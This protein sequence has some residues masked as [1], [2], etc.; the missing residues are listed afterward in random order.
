MLSAI[1]VSFLPR[2]ATA[3]SCSGA[4][5][6]VGSSTSGDS[7][8]GIGIANGNYFVFITNMISGVSTVKYDLVST[9]STYQSPTKSQTFPNGGQGV[10]NIG[11]P[12]D[13]AWNGTRYVL[14]GSNDYFG[15][16]APGVSSIWATTN[17]TQSVNTSGTRNRIVYG[18][19]N[20]TGYFFTNNLTDNVNSTTKFSISTDG[21]TWSIGDSNSGQAEPIT[22]VAY[23][24]NVFTALF[25][26]GRTADS[27]MGVPM[28]YWGACLTN[29][30]TAN[31]STCGDWV[32]VEH[33]NVQNKFYAVS[34]LGCLTSG[35]YNNG[36]TSQCIT[37]GPV[38]QPFS[39]L[40]PSCITGGAVVNIERL[41]I[42]P[43]TGIFIAAWAS[44]S[45]PNTCR[46]A[47]ISKAN[48]GVNWDTVATNVRGATIYN[49]ILIGIG[50]VV[51]NDN[52]ISV[53]NVADC[54]KCPSGQC[55][56]TG[57]YLGSATV[58]SP[59]NAGYYTPDKDDT[60]YPCPTG[61]VNGAQGGTSQGS[62]MITC[63][64]GYHVATANAQCT[65]C[66]AGTYCP[67]LSSLYYGSVSSGTV[68]PA[69]PT[70]PAGTTPTSSTCSK[71][72]TDCYID[73]AA[74]TATYCSGTKKCYYATAYDNCKYTLNFCAAG[75]YDP[76]GGTATSTPDGRCVGDDYYSGNGAIIKHLCPGSGTRKSSGC[77]IGAGTGVGA[78]DAVDCA[79]FLKLKNN[80]KIGTN[81]WIILRQT[82]GT[83]SHIDA[84]IIKPR[85]CAK[86]NGETYC[87][88]LRT[89]NPTGRPLFADFTQSLIT[90]VKIMVGGTAHFLSNAPSAY[91]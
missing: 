48:D 33:S 6:N 24:N 29:T 70:G 56:G 74:H 20:G 62:C 39:A 89:T 5:I 42:D 31:Y 46:G 25:K 66:P 88:E 37:W 81:D 8:Q 52:T 9:L 80:Q 71:I 17:A 28:N 16:N 13:V 53:W 87:A 21:I 86:H 23:G 82:T 3:L 57:S 7:V 12:K 27:T 44:S 40:T 55:L 10:A 2:H 32:G 4:G 85:L 36:A 67:Y 19:R 26:G 34:K 77:G 76:N 18:V 63:Q 79:P 54:L 49:G 65:C 75:F 73:G 14:V 72:I 59:V 78:A 50:S 43:I 51:S 60:C 83:Y 90:G 22:S 1:V 64:Q 41:R 15:Y 61:Y 47:F 45:T 58:C 69:C 91:Y 11:V 30:M 35:T 84:K 38:S 68:K